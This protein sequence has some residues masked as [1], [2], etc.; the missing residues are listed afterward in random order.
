[1]SAQIIY[2]IVTAYFILLIAIGFLTRRY[3]ERSYRDYLLGALPPIA[4]ALH[5]VATLYSGMSYIGAS[6]LNYAFGV[7]AF[8]ELWPPVGMIL[9]TTIFGSRLWR[10]I[11]KHNLMTIPD[12]LE[13][14]F[15]GSLMR[16]L[17]AIVVFITIVILLIGQWTA[18]G[19][20]L[21]V[22]LGLPF[23][24]AVVLG[25][26]ITLFY[27][28]IGGIWAVA[29]TD[30]V[31]GLTLMVT[32]IALAIIGVSMVGGLDNL[33]ARLNEISPALTA[34]FAPAGVFS[35]PFLA[36]HFIVTAIG[37]TVHPR[38][39]HRIYSVR[40]ESFFK[41]LPI[42][43]LT[44]Y[45]IAF[46][47][48][49]F[50]AMA[51]RVLVE[52]G[53]MPRPPTSDWALPY[54]ARYMVDPILA[55]FFL[56][57]LFAACMSTADSMLV[58]AAA[59]IS[60]DIYQRFINPRADDRK[61]IM[62]SKVAVLAIGLVAMLVALEPP[63]IIPWFIWVAEGS[64]GATLGTIFIY[65]LFV[66]RLINRYGAAASIIVGLILSFAIGY[67]ARFIAPLPI[68]AFFIAFIVTLVLCPIVTLATKR[69]AA[70]LQ[71]VE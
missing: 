46:I 57:G 14:R 32:A 12:Y 51:T 40:S 23:Q 31:Q 54:F 29:W 65:A 53:A 28:V 44:A 6:G 24:V 52:G 2:T 3:A 63:A 55:G 37:L 35:M 25:T 5:I 47:T 68:S 9:L 21:T 1:M 26:A 8:W 27:T 39:F 66:P 58:T 48:P 30:V 11:R 56:A 4:I 64:A 69:K 50:A 43:C 16:I 61:L 38:M 19:I 59:F 71:R 15:G 7:S 60:R 18:V 13:H 34:T 45:V 67:Y 42:V 17:G 70:P 36:T 49:K 20:G 10:Y 62:I 22:L 41:W 33:I